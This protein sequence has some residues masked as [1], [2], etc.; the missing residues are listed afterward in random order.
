MKS[1]S[2]RLAVAAIAVGG[3]G[4]LGGVAAED[5]VR[6]TARYQ[7]SP[8][9][10][11]Y[12]VTPF[13]S[14]PP[15]AAPAVGGRTTVPPAGGQ[16][17]YAPP[18]GFLDGAPN[19]ATDSASALRREIEAGIQQANQ[20]LSNSGTRILEGTRSVGDGFNAQLQDLGASTGRQLEFTGSNLRN[21]AEQTLG[22]AADGLRQFGGAFGVT[23]PPSAST[24]STNGVGNSPVV[25]G[26]QPPPWPANVGASVGASQAPLW[27]SAGAPAAT[28]EGSTTGTSAPGGASTLGAA[29]GLNRG[30]GPVSPPSGWTTMNNNTAA[31]PLISPSLEPPAGRRASITGELGLGA[32]QGSGPLNLQRA[33]TAPLGPQF[34]DAPPLGRGTIHSPLSDPAVRGETA[35]QG[36][37]GA[38]GGN[39]PR[40]SSWAFPPPS[41]PAEASD[42][43]NRPPD[44]GSPS[45]AV[46][47]PSANNSQPGGT[48]ST[49]PGRGGA[50]AAT[51]ANPSN[52]NQ[53][54]QQ[55]GPTNQPL[56]I[57]AGGAGSKSSGSGA[58]SLKSTPTTPAAPGEEQP[59]MPLVLASL[60]LVGSL[61]ANLFL[62][63]SYV[64]ARQKY[65]TLVRKTADKF[66]R[67]AEAA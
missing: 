62:G 2:F 53:T 19:A 31:P 67:A 25:G 61:S 4:A 55:A 26:S 14:P 32:A 56:L 30:Q 29:G 49:N 35:S 33:E 12:G 43:F 51:T 34:P 59:W 28:R 16:S 41:N 42:P 66:R 1:V 54:A 21:T 52:L 37:F 36:N 57:G 9:P 38:P 50:P 22:T 20:Q 64:D 46:G 24:T 13:N 27:T 23:S 10:D 5:P 58:T 65:R 7:S 3:F 11:R 6:H 15:A 48:P 63:W 44:F 8:P 60:A 47:A 18:P 45:G 40:D 17:T 39:T